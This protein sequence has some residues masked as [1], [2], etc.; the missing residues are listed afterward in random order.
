MGLIKCTRTQEIRAAPEV[1]AEQMLEVD[2]ALEAF[3][4]VL[5]T[6]TRSFSQ[7]EAMGIPA[8]A[9]CLEFICGIAASVPVRLYEVGKE[10]REITDDYRLRILNEDTGD[11]LSGPEWKKAFFIDYLLRGRAWAYQNMK[12]NRLES[13][14][15]VDDRAVSVSTN[16]DP[17]FK[18]AVV[19]IHGK[20]YYPWQ[21]IHMARNS[22]DGVRGQGLLEQANRQLSMALNYID[23]ENA[24]VKGGGSK[25]GFLQSDRKLDQEM[26]ND[27]KSGFEKMYGTSYEG[28]V[29][30]N[31]GVTFTP[32]QATS[33]EM[34]LAENKARNREDICSLL[35]LSSDIIT[36]KAK[37]EDFYRGI[38]VA[39][40]P[41][42]DRFDK[43]LNR[44]ALLESEKD[45]MRFACD[46]RDLQNSEGLIKRYNAYT[47]A[48]KAGWLSKNEIR[49]KEKLQAID[50]LDVVS[51]G[52]G[53]VIY[54]IKTG[55]YFVPNTG[56]T[57]EMKEINAGGQEG[58]ETIES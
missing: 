23:F 27:L 35:C 26:L 11:L 8:L 29:I 40:L 39:V 48:C 51:L 44:A 49:Y 13:L 37:A 9:G 18:D 43:A 42:L 6:T 2:G 25:R 34:Q 21:F 52:L 31:K 57:V 54:D 17:I 55:K 20:V 24:L 38:Q 3:F 22:R 47:A 36:G 32:A 30:L 19:S 15:Y 53:D 41:L 10:E 45:H 28:F 46:T 14:H 1:R 33:V 4:K 58:D 50:G 7:D 5:N 12:L 16:E 56:Q